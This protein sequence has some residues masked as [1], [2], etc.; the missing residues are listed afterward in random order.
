MYLGQQ[1]TTHIAVE[2]Y[3]VLGNRV[4]KTNTNNRSLRINTSSFS[5][6]IYILRVA[7]KTSSK[8]FKIIKN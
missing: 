8:S 3:T 2:I 6:G 5:K 1:N 7:T 4:F